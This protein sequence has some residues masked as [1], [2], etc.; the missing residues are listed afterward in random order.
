MGVYE[1]DMY[2]NGMVELCFSCHPCLAISF[3]EILLI[4]GC[5]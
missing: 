1:T 5:L 4:Y 3:Y 2:E